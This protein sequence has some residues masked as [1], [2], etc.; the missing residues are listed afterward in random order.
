VVTGAANVTVAEAGCAE[1]GLSVSVDGFAVTPEGRPEMETETEPL[2]EFSEEAVMVMALLVAPA[3]KE[4]EAGEDVREKSG[5]GLGAASPP[6]ERR[7]EV[8]TRA[9]ISRAAGATG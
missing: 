1:V 6:H 4:R 8:N 7:R 2:K 5:V 9:A 3:V